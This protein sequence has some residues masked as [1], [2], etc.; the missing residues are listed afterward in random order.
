MNPPKVLVLAGSARRQALSKRMAQAAAHALAQAG[1]EPS[2]VDLA[3]YPQ[4]LYDGDLEAEQGLP[5]RTV[6]LQ[7]LLAS[8]EALL[9][10]TPEYNGSVTPLLK[11]TLD[12]CSRTNPADPQRS[13]LAVYAGKPAA[14]ASASPG[15]LG[16]MR[17]LFH[18]RDLLGYLGMLVIPQQLAVGGAH[19]AIE[20]DGHTLKAPRQQQALQNMAAALVQLARQRADGGAA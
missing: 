20:A 19:E 11:N 2:F 14:I 3:D 9:V 13:G 7:R 1:A 4:P 16:G 15:A 17:A 5:E 12:W 10:V 18:L 6:A 8:H